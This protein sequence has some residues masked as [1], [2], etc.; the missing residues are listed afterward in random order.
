MG[1]AEMLKALEEAE[2]ASSGA[3]APPKVA[4]K[5]K[6][7]TPAEKEARHQRKKTGASTSGAWPKQ[8]TEEGWAPTPPTQ[9]TEELPE[10]PPVITIAEAS[11]PSKNKAHR[12]VN[13]TR[14]SF[15]E[16]MGQHSKQVE[17]L[18]ELEAVM[19]QEKRAA[20]AEK[21]ALEAQLAAERVARALE[22]QLATERVARAVKEE[23]IRSELDA[24]LA[25]KTVI[26][27]ELEETK[28]RAEEEAERLRSEAVRAWDLGK[29]E[30]LKSSEFETLCAKKAFG[31][32]KVGF[33]SCLTQF[34][35][36]GYSEEEQPDF[37]LN[38]KKALMDM[39]DEEA[40][41]EE[42]EE[43]EKDD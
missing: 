28:A 34:R 33:S 20:G 2:A 26:E 9:M 11:S 8:T 25:K 18:E 17:R 21:E 23:T 5:R 32:F 12:A 30:F 29:G 7:S 6:A 3:A 19:A 4:K 42:E 1:K 27:V 22:A 38:L 24:A 43:E 40:V 36:N 39:A 13:D 10:L 35:A 31:Y 14:Q 41:E 16:M 15:D 37:F